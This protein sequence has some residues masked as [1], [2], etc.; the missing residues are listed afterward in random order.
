VG[1]GVIRAG[2]GADSMI[3]VTNFA[4][5]IPLGIVAPDHTVPTARFFRAALFQALRAWL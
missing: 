4:E 2:V 1:Y 3:G 5:Q